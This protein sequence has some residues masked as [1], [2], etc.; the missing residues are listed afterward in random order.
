ML[1]TSRVRLNV[2]P[3]V[4]PEPDWERARGLGEVDREDEDGLLIPPPGGTE[5]FD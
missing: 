1:S 4:D 5:R 3:V 2:L